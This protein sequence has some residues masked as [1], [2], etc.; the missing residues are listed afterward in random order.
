[1]LH[2][3]VKISTGIIAYFVGLASAFGVAGGLFRLLEPM[4]RSGII[5][6]FIARLWIIGWFYFTLTAVMA[7]IAG[8]YIFAGPTRFGD[9]NSDPLTFKAVLW[10]GV[11]AGFLGALMWPLVSKRRNTDVDM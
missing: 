10:I 3:Q 6:R 4:R 1:M 11:A 9:Y 5:A 7:I 2:P 8:P